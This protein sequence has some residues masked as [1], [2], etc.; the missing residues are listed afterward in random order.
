MDAEMRAHLALE[1][2]QNLR[3]GLAADQARQ[4]A[5][6]S[7]GGIEQ[8]KERERDER[9]FRWVHE[10]I[11]DLRH[12][13]R[14]MLKQPGFSIV[15][16]L[17]LALGLSVN[18]SVFS[19]ISFF[20]FKPLPVQGA[21]RLVVLARQTEQMELALPIS[22]PDFRNLRDEVPEFEDTLALAF[23]PAHLSRPGLVPER[24]WVELVS[25][26]YFELLGQQPLHGRLFLPGE[27]QQPGADP[28]VV[29]GHDFWQTRLGADPRIVGETV[30][31]NGQ[32]FQVIGITRP[33]FSSVQ[34]ALLPA[35]FLP[36][37]MIAT[38]FPWD[39]GA[40]ESRDWCIFKVFGK[41]RPGATV[42][43]ARASV[44]VVYQ[45]LASERASPEQEAKVRVLVLPELMSRPDPSV[46]SMM[47]FAAAVFMTLVLLVLLIACANVAN[48]LFARALA[49]Q[50]EMGIR[51]ALGATRGRLTR[52]L[53]TESV[54]LALLAGALGLAV[55][56]WSAPLLQQLAPANDVPV[57][58]DQ[59]WDWN[60]VW[61]TLAAALL[62][63][64]V[65]GLIPAR[66]A[67]AADVQSVLKGA[68]PQGRGRHWF[69]SGLVMAQVGF[70]VIVLVCGGLFVRSLNRSAGI[71]LGF[72]P[73]GL[74][75][76][77]IDP[78]LNG[79][80]EERSQALIEEMIERVQALPGVEM[81]SVATSVP[82]SNYINLRPVRKAGDEALTGE[83]VG[84]REVQAGVNQVHRDHLATMG[85]T[86]MRGRAFSRED[87]ATSRP[88]V[89]VNETLARRLWPEDEALGQSMVVMGEGVRREVVGV[90]RDGK[91]LMLNE[92]PRGFIFLPI[93]QQYGGPL[94]LHVKLR[95]GSG[96]PADA[97]MLV[98]GVR[99][100]LQG[101][102][103]DLPIFDVR[104]MEEHL[105]G[106]VFG[107]MPLRFAATLAAVQGGLGL[108]LAIMGI[109]GVVAYSVG[110]RTSEIGVRVALGATPA[111]VIRLVMRSG[112]RLTLAG[113]VVGLIV[114]LGFSH[115]LAGLLY[116]LNPVDGPVFGGVVILLLLVSGLACYLPAR[117][118]L[119]V[120]PITA[121]RSE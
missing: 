98:P 52:Q 118:A 29:L 27:G 113:L 38:A 32:P 33:T 13:V 117:R 106:S 82:F 24:A 77:S 50:R 47:P 39:A 83:D 20:F 58:P 49:R 53:L 68:P 96:G 101:L 93:T 59:S 69:R 37:T 15:A 7:F 80:T 81:A 35:A 21:D 78:G 18:I 2:E 71:E 76:A 57:K 17:T 72:R 110:Q 70:C 90:V 64:V 30:I 22:W 1:T 112:L 99:R 104:T 74:V 103:P 65:M 107:Y 84:A 89:I 91:Y 10:L 100:V 26:N 95:R 108:F 43:Q 44:A 19:I 114:A 41:L 67:T 25:G 119:R 105:R 9:G 120:D 23:R 73:A 111:Q 54:L 4:A 79:Y 12:G 34:W 85:V 61:F 28:V 75:M 8:L 63:G 5:Q 6:R 51:S 31:I 3:R 121:L 97:E 46:A 14:L 115:V 116:G 42:E 36:A 11:Q 48:L 88:V 55:S 45:R 62:A 40:L 60:G 87:A 92:P 102:D 94:I 66:R 56:T 86:V 16:I 109:Y